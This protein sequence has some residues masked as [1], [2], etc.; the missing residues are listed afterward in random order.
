[1]TEIGEILAKDFK[2]HGYSVVTRE[3]PNFVASIAA[4][5]L[6]ELSEAMNGWGI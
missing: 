5:L 6:S 4:V 1:M 3:S 2:Q